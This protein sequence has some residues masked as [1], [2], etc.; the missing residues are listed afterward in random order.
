[1]TF[2]IKAE[3]HITSDL[4]VGTG[5]GVGRVVDE[6]VR[7]DSNG[8]PY[9][10]GSTLK[11]L[12]RWQAERLPKLGERE[13][14]ASLFGDQGEPHGKVHFGDARLPRA[15]LTK[16]RPTTVLGRSSRDRKTGRAKD[17][18]LFRL[19][20]ATKGTYTAILEAPS[21]LDDD[22][23]LL[24]IAALRRIEAIGGQRRR[25]K[26]QAEVSVTVEQ[27]PAP[28]SGLILPG[29]EN[30]VFESRLRQRLE[31]TVRRESSPRADPSVKEDGVITPGSGAPGVRMV[32]AYAEEP[33]ALPRSPE[34]GNVIHTLPYISGSSVRG[35]WA[36][37]FRH[38]GM[39]TS[40][41]FFTS[42]F[43]HEKLRFG[44]L[45]PYEKQSDT[46]LPL[47]LP[48]SLLT[49]KTHPGA[50]DGSLPTT[51]VHGLVDVLGQSDPLLTCGQSLHGERTCESPFKPQSGFLQLK[52]GRTGGSIL[53]LLTTE[54][55]VDQHVH[56]HDELER[57]EDDALY[58]LETV[59]AGS[60]FAGYIWGPADLLA[61]LDSLSSGTQRTSTLWVGKARTRGHGK[62]MVVLK[63]PEVQDHPSYPGLLPPGDLSHSSPSDDGFILTLYSDLI[64][65]DPLLR[66]V[67][68]LGEGE[69]WALLSGRGTPAFRL[70]RGYSAVRR[71]PGFNGVPR[72]PRSE[73]IA[74]V[75][76]STWR[77]FWTTKDQELRQ[78]VMAK[79]DQAV[80]KGLGL[81]QG[82]GYGRVLV[83]LPIQ[84]ASLDQTRSDTYTVPVTTALAKPPII[85]TPSVRPR[86]RPATVIHRLRPE[87]VRREDRIGVAR[88]LMRSVHDD[89]LLEQALTEREKH[90]ETKTD[91]DVF[92][93]SVRDLDKAQRPN[94]AKTCAERLIELDAKE[95][96]ERPR[97]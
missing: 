95:R 96:G 59:P 79:L 49:C 87:S 28:W 75:A 21:G 3:L 66:P 43:T 40:D 67:T 26:G 17:D 73:D 92:L 57:A 7:K 29:D 94:V 54:T 1:M 27:G 93:Q 44:P 70:E 90:N 68:R 80:C 50:R 39:T 42:V 60:W 46:S 34:A 8:W 63:K 10:P 15:G 89:R 31:P 85:P 77:F 35:A 9:I 69:L 45:Y 4:H 55:H 78:E 72:L 32:F 16:L 2:R 91:T 22:E 25:G 71:I 88:L 52:K 33:L 61:R 62:V 5:T 48:R 58:G 53:R 6:E 64:A 37:S 24:L 18:H 74:L 23:I 86:Y 11:G 83:D 84:R 81:R 12:A 65:L 51:A 19:E 41:R 82:E 97:R 36:A 30:K 76:G 13:V 20:D 56:I 14:V 47:P 38:H